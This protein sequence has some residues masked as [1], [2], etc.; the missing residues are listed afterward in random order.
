M[1]MKYEK[2]YSS[3]TQRRGRD[4]GGG[5]GGGQ[6]TVWAEMNRILYA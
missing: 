3:Q 5:G 6:E 1:T 2:G 4:G